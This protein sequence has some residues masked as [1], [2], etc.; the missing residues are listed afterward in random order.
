MTKD[1]LDDAAA[2]AVSYLDGLSERNVFPAP[3]AL[4]GLDRFEEPLPDGPGDPAETLRMLDA[5]GSPATT[6]TAGPR[7]FG[8]VIGGALPATVAAR[9][10]C[11]PTLSLPSRVPRSC[12]CRQA[13]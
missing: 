8:F 5:F 7:Y 4:G 1:L 9:G 11:V 12:A 13:T 3:D 2:R 6:A 10:A